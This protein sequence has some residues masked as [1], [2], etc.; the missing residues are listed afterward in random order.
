M[1]P[2]AVVYIDG[3]KIQQ[4]PLRA[5]AISAGNHKILLVNDTKGK[6]EEIKLKVNPGEPL[7]DIKRT[8]D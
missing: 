8:W 5:Y 7:A 3:K 1:R 6:R 2:W 4:T